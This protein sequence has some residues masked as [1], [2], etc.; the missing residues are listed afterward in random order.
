MECGVE[1]GVREVVQQL[2]LARL[3]VPAHH[4]ACQ[5]VQYWRQSCTNVRGGCSHTAAGCKSDGL[6]TSQ[7]TLHR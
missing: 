5:H 4:V 1:C 6:W 2:V 7:G 3:G